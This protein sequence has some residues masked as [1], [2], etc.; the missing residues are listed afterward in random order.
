MNKKKIIIIATVVV[1][2]AV[3]GAVIVFMMGG[4][5]GKKS[6]NSKKFQYELGEQYSNVR[7]EGND[8]GARKTIIKYS[9]TIV[10]TNEKLQKKFIAASTELTTEYKKY[11]MSKTEKQLTKLERVSEDLTDITKEVMKDE[12]DEIIN[13]LFGQY[14]LQ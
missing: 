10:Y 8:G 6:R 4:D 12:K 13:V 14:I 2:I 7:M 1:L 11:F 9:P 3:V 5:N